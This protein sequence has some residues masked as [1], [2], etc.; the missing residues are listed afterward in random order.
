MNIVHLVAEYW[1]FA[2]TGGLAEA[3]RGIATH[4]A[5]AGMKTS[6]FMPLYRVARERTG[7]LR[8][9]CEVT[10]PLGGAVHT[11][12]ILRKAE[13]PDGPVTYFVDHPGAFDRAGIYGEG[14]G[15]YPDNHLRFALFARAVLEWQAEHSSAVGRT[16]LFPRHFEA[17]WHSAHGILSAAWGACGNFTPP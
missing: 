11:C 16:N 15:D 4:Q 6:V 3:V 9:C 12:R 8:H 1:P 17:A 14:G 2:R 13:E 10:V 7:E 5:R